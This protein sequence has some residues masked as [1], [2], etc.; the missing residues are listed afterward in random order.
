MAKPVVTKY[1]G[2]QMKQ[3]T[4]ITVATV[5]F[6]LRKSAQEF[7]PKQTRESRLASVDHHEQKE[8]NEDQGAC[9]SSAVHNQ[10]LSRD[11]FVNRRY[12]RGSSTLGREK[13]RN[14]AE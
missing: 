7:W 8:G 11:D 3:K 12:E 6:R 4:V 9:E 14:Q 5:E 2:V 1:M 13:K 10:I